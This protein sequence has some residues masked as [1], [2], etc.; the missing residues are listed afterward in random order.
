MKTQNK[1]I[2]IKARKLMDS[3]FV[4]NF[5]A[6]FHWKWIEFQ[7][8]REYSPS[9]DAKYID[10]A[11]SSREG[12]TIMRRY[13]EDKQWNVLCILDNSIS[14]HF[15]TSQ[16]KYHLAQ[17]IIMLLWHAS[18]A[19]GESFGGYK[20]S[21]DSQEYIPAKK[22]K[23]G[24]YSFMKSSTAHERKERL[25]LDFLLKNVMKRSIIFVV[26]DSLDV[27]AKSFQIAAMKHDIIYL[28]ISENF[29]NTLEWSGLQGIRSTKKLL[30]VN[31]DDRMKK[32]LYRKKR[33][34][35]LDTF[36]K[37]LKSLDIDSAFFD[38]TRPVFAELLGLM[39]RRER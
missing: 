26:S 9:D 11:I 14:L 12:K 37:K 13:R 39:K 38:E 24:L 22:S 16:I 27:D 18:L 1:K 25:S 36:A 7:D 29:E 35:K 23:Q 33:K 10:W 34:E 4:G 8:F 17:E 19:S 21:K 32:E 2:D 5:K 31:L 15:W 3:L 6:A 28:H 20:L 30:G